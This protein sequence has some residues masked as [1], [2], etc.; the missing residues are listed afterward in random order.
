MLRQELQ[1]LRAK[2]DKLE[3]RISFLE[4]LDEDGVGG[5]FDSGAAWET[6]SAVRQAKDEGD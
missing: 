5:E 4:P 1:Q 3:Q 6:N 2:V